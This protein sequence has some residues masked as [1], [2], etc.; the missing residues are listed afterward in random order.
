MNGHRIHFGWEAD[1][2]IGLYG[3][4]SLSLKYVDNSLKLLTIYKMNQYLIQLILYAIRIR[5]YNA[6]QIPMFRY[7]CGDPLYCA[8]CKKCVNK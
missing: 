2:A 3:G 7:V 1:S 5:V 6:K 4:N 8:I